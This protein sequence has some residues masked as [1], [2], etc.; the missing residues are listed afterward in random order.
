[1]PRGMPAWSSWPAGSCEWGLCSTNQGGGG[2]GI[3]DGG[4]ILGM[5]TGACPTPS[6]HT[7][8]LVCK[9]TAS[10]HLTCMATAW[11]QQTVCALHASQCCLDLQCWMWWT[12]ACIH[13]CWVCMDCSVTALPQALCTNKPPTA[14]SLHGQPH[15]SAAAL[16]TA[17]GMSHFRLIHKSTR[18]RL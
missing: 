18:S 4:C 8:C 7:T 1:M 12:K 13:V 6:S 9:C 15:A 17:N 11:H 16:G 3:K 5:P 14:C 2:D 10:N